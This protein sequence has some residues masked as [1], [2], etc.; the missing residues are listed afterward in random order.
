[1]KME[2][3]VTTKAINAGLE[4]LKIMTY[5]VLL[6]FEKEGRS[7]DFTIDL[8]AS[9]REMD[10]DVIGTQET[11]AEMHEKC[12]C[13][14]TEYACYRG[15]AYT[16]NN[17]RG[18]YVYWKEDK[19]N[20]LEMGHRY[21]SDTPTVRS[22]YE[23]SREYRGFNYLL[24]ESRETGNRFLFLNLHADYRADEET[25]VLQLKTVSA[26]LKDE[27]W[28]NIPAI[29]VGDFNSTAEQA[30][31]SA[32]LADNANIGMTSEIAREK[33]DTGPT[34]VC[35]LFTKRDPYVFDYIFV[36]KDLIN[37]KYYSVVDNIKNGKY[38]SDHLPVVAELEIGLKA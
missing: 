26:F 36:T 16:E 15:E 1:M 24:L 12:L 19:F 7:P 23:R 13:R 9:I 27:K 32:F 10:P 34:L 6:N 33:G 35:G 29:I 21:M 14:L 38:P 18:N 20:A 11:T 25:R 31:I 5:N 22:K 3:Q 28:K 37:T 17:L 8:E 30:S 4:T 2:K